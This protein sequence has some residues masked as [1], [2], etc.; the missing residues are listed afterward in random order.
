MKRKDTRNYPYRGYPPAAGC[1]CRRKQDRPQHREHAPGSP[2]TFTEVKPKKLR[3]KCDHH[4]CCALKRTYWRSKSSYYDNN[5]LMF[6]F[7]NHWQPATNHLYLFKKCRVVVNKN[8]NW[9]TVLS[10][11]VHHLMIWLSASYR[12]DTSPVYTTTFLARYPFEFG[13]GPLNF[14]P[15]TLHFCRVNGKIRGTSAPKQTSAET[16]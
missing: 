9:P 10:E 4:Y 2:C 14:Q 7:D 3:K 1:Y 5:L 6:F 12:Q 15:G 13:P 11:Y 8:R 16:M